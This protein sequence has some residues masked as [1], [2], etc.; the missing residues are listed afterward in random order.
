MVLT[1]ECTTSQANGGDKEVIGEV[2]GEGDGV[3]G[4][5]LTLASTM[6]QANGGD[7]E[8]VGKVGGGRVCVGLTTTT[9]LYSIHQILISDT[10]TIGI[11]LKWQPEFRQCCISTVHADS[12]ARHHGIE[13]G[14]EILAPQITSGEEISNVY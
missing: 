3:S 5:A 8:V 2:A 4:T 11:N 10:G 14:N 1:L 13:E 12:I 6:S 9:K 7:N